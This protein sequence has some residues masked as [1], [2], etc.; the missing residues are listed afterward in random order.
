MKTIF[1]TEDMKNVLDTAFN[2]NISLVRASNGVVQYEN[3]NDE[4][5]VIINAYDGTQ[6]E[7][8]L[9][10]MLD[11]E[12][13]AWKERTSEPET[14]NNLFGQYID[15]FDS[16]LKKTYALVEFMG[17]EAVASVDVDSATDSGL[18]TFLVQTDKIKNFDYYCRKVRNGF[19][20]VPQT[21]LT[22]DGKELTAFITLGLPQYTE[23]PSLIQF[24]ECLVAQMTIRMTYLQSA[25]SYADYEF[26][27]SLD[28]ETYYPI[29]LTQLTWQE[30]FTAQSVAKAN[31]P[32]INGFV[33]STKGSL[34]S[35][36]YFD[37]KGGATK[38]L[39]Q[40]FF[41]MS[42]VEIQ[43]G[44]ATPVP[45][46]RGDVNIPIWFSVKDKEA[47]RTYYYKDVI[48]QMEKVF[49]NTDFTIASITLRSWGKA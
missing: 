19:L 7:E 13:Y 9:A 38:L 30:I 45:T 47:D 31:R 42:A 29:A 14:R 15:S 34:K 43:T 37:F 35:L 4:N 40:K 16:S 39:T 6:R 5:V 28:G 48:T 20:G 1:T 26:K 11:I 17:E 18:V 49:K 8:S 36:A 24:G 46:T 25:N 33:S 32:D 10:K 12:F 2:G 41:E 23:E 21:I 27:L 22:A 44:T 3:P